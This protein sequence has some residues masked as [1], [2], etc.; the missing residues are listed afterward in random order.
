MSTDDAKP[1]LPEF[2]PVAF[3]RWLDKVDDGLETPTVEGLTVRPLYTAQDGEAGPRPPARTPGWRIA[4]QYGCGDVSTLDEVLKRDVSRGLEAA[5]VTLHG[6]LRAGAAVSSAAT[7][8]VLTAASIPT[9]VESLTTSTALQLDAG[10]AAPDL[11]RALIDARGKEAPRDAVLCDPLAVLASA[12]GLGVSLDDAYAQLAQTTTLAIEAGTGLA[13]I[14]IDA[15]PAHDA[16][17]SA[18]QEVAVAIA[19]GLEHLQRLQA[20][21]LDAA[22]VMPHIVMQM[23]V[24]GD[25]L[26]EVAKLRAVR[27]LWARVRA[28]AGAAEGAPT[29]LWVRTS[30][31]HA[32]VRDPWVNLL[33]G[34]VGAFAAIVGGCSVL[35]VQ[36]FTETLGAPEADA[37]RWAINTQHILR[38]ESHL[39]AVDDP[40]AGSF[41]F[42]SLTDDLAKGAW[43]RVREWLGAGGMGEVLTSG[44]L[45]GEIAERAAARS[46]ALATGKLVATGTTAYP[47]LD[48]PQLEVPAPTAPSSGVTRTAAVTALPLSTRRLTEPFE[49]LRDR[50]DEAT[51]ARGRRPRAMLVPVGDPRRARGQIDFARGFAN[52]GGF[53]VLLMT[54]DATLSEKVQLAILCGPAEALEAEGPAGARRLIAGGIARV[55]VAGRPTD[56]LREAGVYD[57]IHRGRD[58]VA[59]LGALQADLFAST[60]E[61]VR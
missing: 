12:G 34:T 61:A 59:V 53:E 29:P 15:V 24:G 40:A 7:G 60:S 51:Q 28:H 19:T 22:T 44:R 32:T 37:R 47:S 18:E 56:A 39:G 43:A 38:G 58:V 4:Q 27:R 11:A 20:A 2:S 25:L 8:S 30:W 55:L 16:G 6:E 52:V 33:R 17:A 36:P 14:A 42:E 45:Q 9:L 5:W 31:R 23:A 21:G 57:F 54:P 10:L 49:A 50:A 48:E 26:V 13:T 1:L 41:A 3:D 35:A 46:T